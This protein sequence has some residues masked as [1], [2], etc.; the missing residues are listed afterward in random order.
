MMILDAVLPIFKLS[1]VAMAVHHLLGIGHLF[2]GFAIL[3]T[4][5]LP[6]TLESVYLKWLNFSEPSEYQRIV[7]EH[8]V[9]A[10]AW[11]NPIAFPI[12]VIVE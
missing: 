4:L 5:L 1:T 8:P 6:G 2:W 7:S 10:K 12:F 9:L 11:L 3:G